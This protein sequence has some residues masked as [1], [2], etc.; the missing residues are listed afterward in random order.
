MLSKIFYWTDISFSLVLTAAWQ[1]FVGCQQLPSAWKYPRQC[2]CPL[3]C[4]RCCPR[5]SQSFACGRATQDPCCSECL[6]RQRRP[7]HHKTHHPPYQHRRTRGD[8]RRRPPRGSSC[9]FAAR[10]WTRSVCCRGCTRAASPS[11]AS[12]CGRRGCPSGW[13]V[14]RKNHRCTVFHPCAGAS[15]SQ[16]YTSAKTCG[17]KFHREMDGAFLCAPRRL[18]CPGTLHHRENSS[19]LQTPPPPPPLAEHQGWLLLLTYWC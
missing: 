11:C 6:A 12:W 5:T 1:P 17:H 2:R 9:G 8:R 19:W 15:G 18:P 4:R 3:P 13:S 16:G 10:T 7:P 14:C